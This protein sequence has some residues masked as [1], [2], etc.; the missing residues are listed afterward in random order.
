[1]EQFVQATTQQR[2]LWVQNVAAA[3]IEPRMVE[4]FRRAGKDL[5]LLIVAED[6][7]PDSANTV[8]Y[9]AALAAQAG[10]DL[11]IVDRVSGAAIMKRHP[12]PDGR[13]V[14]PVVVLLRRQVDVAAWVERPA[15]LQSLFQSIGTNPESARQ[16]AQR[17]T[18]YDAD[19]GRTTVAEIVTLAEQHTL[20][21]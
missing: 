21:R 17:Q 9:V 7:C 3:K 5:R 19:R 11:R 13:A 2:N 12:A 10:I 1:M 15:L 16:F 4:R 18:W 20:A 14:T 6:W 8:P